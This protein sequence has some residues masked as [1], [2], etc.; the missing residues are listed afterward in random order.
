LRVVDR[1]LC[2]DDIRHLSPLL[3]QSNKGRAFR[4]HP[5]D[6]LHD[7][8]ELNDVE[9]RIQILDHSTIGRP[10]IERFRSPIGG[11]SAR[12]VMRRIPVRGHQEDEA[13][14]PGGVP[15]CTYPDLGG[16][17]KM[18]QDQRTMLMM[19][20]ANGQRVDVTTGIP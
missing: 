19:T 16:S 11:V 13:T 17:H 10:S 1:L 15:A 14:L 18:N 8:L 2:H 20:P 6:G 9:I 3:S 12:A 4:C 7:S 5:L